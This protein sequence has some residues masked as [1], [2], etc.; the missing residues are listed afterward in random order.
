MASAALH[1]RVTKRR[2]KSRMV[3]RYPSLS[4]S[5][6]YMNQQKTETETET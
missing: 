3:S 4:P 1:G 2:H 6:T 5:R